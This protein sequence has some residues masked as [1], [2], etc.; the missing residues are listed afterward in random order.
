[1][2]LRHASRKDTIEDIDGRAGKGK[3]DGHPGRKGETD[4]P[5]GCKPLAFPK[6][7][8]FESKTRP[9]F[10]KRDKRATKLLEARMFKA[11]VPISYGGTGFKETS[12]RA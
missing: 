8:W 3:T 7:V 10:P 5:F 11:P 6:L 12:P 2:P 9:S 4:G 1:M